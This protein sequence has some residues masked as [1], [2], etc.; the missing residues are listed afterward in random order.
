MAETENAAPRVEISERKRVFDGFFKLDE[1][2]VRIEQPGGALSE[3]HRYLV[4]ERGDSVATLVHDVGARRVLLVEQFR[5]ATYEKGPGWLL[6]PAA[7]MI[8]PGET[9]EAAARRELEEELGIVATELEAVGGVFLSPGGSSERIFL[10]YAPVKRA[11]APEAS[12]LGVGSE[13]DS[14]RRRTLR[15][16][17]L[18]RM[19]DKGAIEDAK[20]MI[21]AQ[22]LRRRM[23]TG[24]ARRKRGAV[25]AKRQGKTPA[26]QARGS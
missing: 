8:E 3:P 20:L 21:L 14:L 11:D 13:R 24:G 19:L 16:S 25:G 7:G 2:E 22:W 6:E 1:A 23:E 10:F 9:P 18:F 4:L 12:A 5:F 15:P 26:R 17:E